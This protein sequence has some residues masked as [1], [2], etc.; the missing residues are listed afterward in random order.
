[1]TE[2]QPIRLPAARTR[3]DEAT[4]T[5]RLARIAAAGPLRERARRR[6]RRF[7][8]ALAVLV[9]AAVVLIGA[10][11]ATLVHERSAAARSATAM[12]VLASAR[13]A[14][15]T[16]LTADPADPDG[17][18][19][20]ALAVTTGEQHDR[21]AGARDAITAEISGQTTPSTGQVLAAGLITDPASDDEGAQARVLVVADATDPALIGEDGGEGPVTVELTMTR[22]AAGWLIGE[23]ARS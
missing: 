16:L 23:A 13:S 7:I 20:R 2:T 1:M 12:E 19:D 18:L 4:R 21:L 14:I 5:A 3:V 9:V 22:T 11:T 17:Y 15:T 10:I 8:V 6:S